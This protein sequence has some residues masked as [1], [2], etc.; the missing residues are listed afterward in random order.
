MSNS[1]IPKGFAGEQYSDDVALIFKIKK[2][3]VAEKTKYQKVDIIDTETYGKI[4]FLDNLLMKTDRDG[5]II[6]EMI[7]HVPM[8]VGRKKKKVLVIGAGEGF[9]ASELLKYPYIEKIDV[10]DIDKDFV[11]ISKGIYPEK[12]KAFENKKV[13]LFIADGLEFIKQAKEKYDVIFVTPTDPANLSS[14]LFTDEFYKL[15]FDNLA[16]D[17]IFMTDAYMPFYKLGDIDYAYM[18]AKLSK[19]Y[20]ICKLYSC[21]VPSFPGGLFTFVIGSKK[22]DPESDANEFDFPIKTDYYNTAFHKAAFKLPQFMLEK[23]KNG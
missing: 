20:K 7:V 3:L 16:D 8:M 14:P 22:Y 6:N 12:T 9:T 2:V 15:C 11:E 19:L 1:I 5:H 10:V 13:S 17:G 4:L 23:L 18:H 21:C